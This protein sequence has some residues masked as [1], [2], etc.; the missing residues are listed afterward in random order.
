MDIFDIIPGHRRSSGGETY[1][2]TNFHSAHRQ[3]PFEMELPTVGELSLK[4]G[5]H[6]TLTIK[7]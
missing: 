6:E 7:M 1:W 4:R 2:E 5:P 3:N